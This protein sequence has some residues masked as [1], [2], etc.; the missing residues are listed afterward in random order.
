MEFG[1]Y[2]TPWEGTTDSQLLISIIG[3]SYTTQ[4]RNCETG[5]TA[6]PQRKCGNR[7]NRGIYIKKIRNNNNNNERR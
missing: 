4:A 3:D 6:T 1:I 7:R 5:S 2:V